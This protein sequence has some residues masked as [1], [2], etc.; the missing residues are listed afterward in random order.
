MQGQSAIIMD[1]SLGIKVS[2]FV[3]KPSTE[4]LWQVFGLQ[5]N[6]TQRETLLEHFFLEASCSLDPL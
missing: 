3:S 2:K 6:L 5:S 4:Y 1:M